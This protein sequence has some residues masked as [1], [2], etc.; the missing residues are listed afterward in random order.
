M[1]FMI[2]KLTRLNLGY[3]GERNARLIEVDVSEWLERYP[4]AAVEVHVQTPDGTDY[5]ADTKVV[6]GVLSWLVTPG[7]L[8][9][10]GEGFAQFVAR[11]KENDITYKSRIVLTTISQSLEN[12]AMADPPEASAAWVETVLDAAANAKE[13]ADAAG[14][15]AADAERKSAPPIVLREYGKPGDVGLVCKMSADKPFIG[16]KMYGK[17]TQDGVPTS[18]A[19]VALDSIPAGSCDVTVNAD[20]IDT[21]TINLIDKLRGIPVSSGGNYTDKSGTHW[22]CDE[23][24]LVRGVLIKRVDVLPGSS[25]DW[26]EN[27]GRF[28]KR[29]SNPRKD[30]EASKEYYPLLCNIAKFA[31]TDTA[32]TCRPGNQGNAGVMVLYAPKGYDMSNVELLYQ[33]EPVEIPL[34]DEEIAACKLLRA[35]RNEGG[36]MQ[37]NNSAGA[38]MLVDYSADTQDYVESVSGGSG[39]G[40]GG[41]GTDGFSPVVDIAKVGNATTITVTDIK[42]T[43]SATIYDGADGAAGAAGKDGTSVSV[44]NVSTSNADG[45]S[46]VV[47]FS[48]GKTVTIKNGSKGS[49]GSQGPAGE[50]GPAGVGIK[51]VVQTTTSTAD[52]GSNVITVTDTSGAT[53]TF[54]V[55]NGSKGSTGA[56]GPAGADGSPGKDGTSVTVKSVSTSSADGGSNVVTFSD[57]KTL[58]V[59][60]GS[61]GSKGDQGETGPAGSNGTNGTNA[62]ITGAT[63]TVDANIGTPSVSVSLGGTSSART[64]AFTFKNLKGATGAAGAAGADGKTPVKGTDYFTASDKADMVSQ[65]KSSLGYKTET[66]TFTLSDGSTVTKK[67]V[68]A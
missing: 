36:Y 23:I 58:T 65:V 51:S 31:T 63:A 4:G 30:A 12:S 68:L 39:G 56:T 34:T 53:S 44:K 26:L 37:V 13:S 45:G 28:Q 40:S 47:T 5:F 57:G 14:L 29:V 21:L 33:C 10:P 18:S 55:K 67:V 41:T 11:D 35:G 38:E 3:V 27:Y 25:M 62:T 16:L 22:V 43:K 19:P 60:N 50:Q 49:Q 7:E 52:G 32:N 46:N 9:V 59:K 48:D 42:G 66:W 20:D 6:A 2:G 1:G 64:F 54:T 17:T 61:K 15:Y 24:D 8:L